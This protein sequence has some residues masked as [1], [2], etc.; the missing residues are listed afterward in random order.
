M[1]QLLTDLP[2]EVL[3]F[4]ATGTVTAEDYETILIPKVAEK[5]AKYGKV[6]VLYHLGTQFDHF[7]WKAFWDDAKVGLAHWTQWEKIGVVTDVIWLRRM[8]KVFGWFMPNPVKIFHNDELELARDW[9][10]G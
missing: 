8:V 3:A 2:D 6:R 4:S 7:S 9:I 10:A 5:L 1:L